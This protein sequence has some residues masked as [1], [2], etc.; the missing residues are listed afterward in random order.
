MAK[1]KMKGSGRLERDPAPPA[2]PQGALA[3]VGAWREVNEKELESL[4]EDIYAGRRSDVGAPGGTRSLI[5]PSHHGRGIQLS[6]RPPGPCSCQGEH[7]HKQYHRPESRTKNLA[8]HQGKSFSS[9]ASTLSL[10]RRTAIIIVHMYDNIRLNQST[11]TRTEGLQNKPPAGHRP[12]RPLRKK[13][14]FAKQ[15][16]GRHRSSRAHPEKSTFAKQT[17]RGQSSRRLPLTPAIVG[18]YHRTRG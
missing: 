4:I 12:S 14:L 7:K 18:N 8:R 9:I 1:R 5:Y 3:L 17:A 2:R 16:G 6:S 15:T 11:S 10:R 13:V